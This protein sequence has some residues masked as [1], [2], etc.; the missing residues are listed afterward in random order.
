MGSR[1]AARESAL[2]MLYA[3]EYGHHAPDVLITDF[4][5]EFPGD[6][7]GRSYADT[8]VR[9]VLVQLVDAA[10]VGV[11]ERAG[12][13]HAVVVFA[14][15]AAPQGRAGEHADWAARFGLRPEHFAREGLPSSSAALARRLLGG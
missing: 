6:A 4:W 5:R 10:H 1:S 12:E 13:A 15:P 14:D 9:G 2:Q 7:E 11:G 3:A 8:A